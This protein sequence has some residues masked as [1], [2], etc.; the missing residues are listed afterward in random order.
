MI[1]MVKVKTYDNSNKTKMSTI[2]EGLRDFILFSTK[3]G[4]INEG[5]TNCYNSRSKSNN[6][7]NIKLGIINEGFKHL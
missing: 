1:I 3:A 5:I 4:T 2:N 6:S 7:N